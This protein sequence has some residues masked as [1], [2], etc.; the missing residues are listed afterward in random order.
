MPA[1]RLGAP[2]EILELRRSIDNLDAALVYLLAERFSLT[3]RVG[4]IK[5]ELALPPEDLSREATQ[6]A[7]IK[8]LAEDAGLE[9]EFA[10]AFRE[11]VTAEVIRRHKR[12]NRTRHDSEVPE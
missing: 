3:H 5:A 7:R 12:L 8:G 11:F 2:P 10:E 6:M 4:E 9:P 1:S